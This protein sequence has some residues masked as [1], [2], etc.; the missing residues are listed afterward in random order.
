MSDNVYVDLIKQIT[1]DYLISAGGDELRMRCPFD[2][3]NDS[4]PSFSMNV[5]T[6]KWI[7]FGCGRKGDAKYLAKLLNLNFEIDEN[8]EAKIQRLKEIKNNGKIVENVESKIYFDICKMPKY[9]CL[10]LKHKTFLNRKIT[11]SKKINYEKDYNV[12]SFNKRY[13]FFLITYFGINIG[14][15]LRNSF[16]KGNRK[17]INSKSNIFS[18]YVYFGDRIQGE[19][20]VWIVEGFLDAIVLQSKDVMTVASFGAH[21]TLGQIKFLKS[22]GVEKIVLFYDYDKAGIQAYH[23]VYNKTK[24]YFDV[25]L[26]FNKRMTDPKKSMMSQLVVTDYDG[27]CRLMKVYNFTENIIKKIIL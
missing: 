12:Y 4:N 10:S 27:W 6:G 20:I 18:N 14:Y 15:S 3:H 2:D 11:V 5:K 1:N 7:C 22:Q 25:F 23:S 24:K 21:L 17:Y 13:I 26:V 16:K 8:N 19:K 9:Y